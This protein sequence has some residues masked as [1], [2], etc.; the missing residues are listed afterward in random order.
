MSRPVS[1]TAIG[2]FVVGALVLLVAGVLVLTR[3]EFGRE[4]PRYVLYFDGSVA[5]LDI[6]A[7]VLF[8]GVSIGKVVSIQI[9]M[10]PNHRLDIPVIVELE[11]EKVHPR[12]DVRVGTG[13]VRQLVH[14]GLRAKLATQSLITGKLLIELSLYPDAPPAT[15]R[16]ESDYPEIP[17]LPSDFAEVT[18]T[19]RSLS[20]KLD[21]L[22][23]DRYAQR[24]DH[25]LARIEALA[26]AND[27]DGMIHD[28]REAVASFDKV[29]TSLARHID[30]ALL[31]LRRA[32]RK[33]SEV[34]DAIGAT[35][36]H[37]DAKIDPLGGKALATL[38][39]LDRTLM[40]GRRA[41]QTLRATVSADSPL[42]NDLARTLREIADAARALRVLSEF[43]TDHPEA[44][45]SGRR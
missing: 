39:S 5:G 16:S 23:L 3:G 1:A 22:P 10:Y 34:M 42:G 9:D 32:S 19:I 8:R 44:I 41:M 18:A 20:R 2:A 40:T 29:V 11:P 26:D 6:G 31:E 21:A 4:R 25:I 7:P 43:L 27:L 33:T 36:R 17:T 38:E 14:E 37:V 15:A 30:P 28:A 13:L 24:V 12:K 45:L 35:V